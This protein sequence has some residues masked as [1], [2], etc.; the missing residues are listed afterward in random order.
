MAQTARPP[1][2]RKHPSQLQKSRTSGSRQRNAASSASLE[3]PQDLSALL[4]MASNALEESANLREAVLGDTAAVHQRREELGRRAVEGM[5]RE[6]DRLRSERESCEAKLAEHL[7]QIQRLELSSQDMSSKLRKRRDDSLALTK[8]LNGLR[9]VESGDGSSDIANLDDDDMRELHN[10]RELEH[11]SNDVEG[12][13]QKS[14]AEKEQLEA[15]IAS[16]RHAITINEALY[17]ARA[18]QLNGR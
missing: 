2:A 14:Y 17:R 6:T 11:K 1:Q 15:G 9:R 16:R 12:R 7:R 10:N 3:Q 8:H 13:L 4:Q 18:E 5:W